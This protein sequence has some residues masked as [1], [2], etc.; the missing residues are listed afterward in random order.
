MHVK[1]YH[2]EFSKMIGST[3]NVADLAY[4]RTV[5]GPIEDYTPKRQ[6]QTITSPPIE[7]KIDT[8]PKTSRLSLPPK[9]E[10]MVEKIPEPEKVPEIEKPKKVP[11][12]PKIKESEIAKLLNSDPKP[13]VLE[14]KISKITNNSTNKKAPNMHFPEIREPPRISEIK[15]T[16]NVFDPKPAG[17]GIRTL[18]PVIRTPQDPEKKYVPP[19]P[20]EIPDIEEPP[21]MPSTKSLLTKAALGKHLKRRR[22]NSEET[23]TYKK[24]RYTKHDYDY[25][26]DFDQG[27]LKNQPLWRTQTSLSLE[28]VK[29]RGK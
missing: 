8:T 17:G 7:R 3:P 20:P 26:P 28:S 14:P 4:A 6:I 1:H 27:M 29:G 19:T 10:P 24:R 15:E 18:L 11:E 21:M 12:I 16:R 23:T 13:L 25:Y 5:G 9:L 2:P 22:N